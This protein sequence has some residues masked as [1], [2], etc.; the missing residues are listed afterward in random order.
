MCAVDKGGPEA[1]WKVHDTLYANQ[2]AEGGAGP[3]DT[4]LIDLA[5]EA[6]VTGIDVVRHAPRS[7]SRGSRR[8]ATTASELPIARSTPPRTVYDRRQGGRQPVAGRVLQAAID[9]AKAA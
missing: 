3:E 2:P 4:A 5:E 7:S 1:F 9:A 8:P 6:G